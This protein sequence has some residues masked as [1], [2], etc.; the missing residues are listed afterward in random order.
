MVITIV[1][2]ACAVINIFQDY[3]N[4]Y[5]H[6]M[7]VSLH[8]FVVILL[9]FGLLT[10]N[11]EASTQDA[12]SRFSFAIS[13]GASKGAYES[14]LNWSVIKIGRE[15]P[16]LKDIT[17]GQA[18]QLEAGSITGAS[19]GGINTLLSGLTWC[20]RSE[21]EGGLS[22]RIDNNV[23]RDIWLRIDINTLLPR[24]ADSPSYLPDDAVLSRKDFLDAAAELRDKWNKPM[25]RK[26]CRIPLGVT[27]TRIEPDKLSVGNVEV[28]NQRFY[29]PFELRVTTDNSIDFFFDP[30]DYPKVADPAMI[31]MP[32]PRNAP[33]FS[34]DDQRVEDAAF[35]TSAFPMAFGR[36]RLQ[37]CRLIVQEISDENNQQNQETVKTNTDLVC[38][39]GYELA[40]AEFAD[41]GLFDNLPIGVA[42]ILA[43]R[44]ARA[45]EDPYPVTY[46]YLDPNRVRYKIP[47]AKKD[48]AC[49][50]PNPPIA[51][52]IM[53]FSFASESQ[54][55]LSFLGTA[56]RYEL[57]R[58]LT[59]EDWQLNM[60]E[61][62]YKL[63]DILREREIILDCQKEI[64]F[65]DRRLD[66]TESLERAGHL[67]EIAY[68]RKTPI[69]EAPYS[70][71]RL[72][73]AGIIKQC[74]QVTSNTGSQ[75]Q[76][77]CAFDI[78]RY[79]KVLADG[80]TSIAEQTKLTR[81]KIYSD[82]SKSRLSM[83]NDRSLR[84]SS[85]SAPITG[86]L[87][88]S[89]GSFL[90]Y[91]FREYDYYVGVYDGLIMVA[92]TSCGLQYS[93]V[94]Q[95]ED[96]RQCFDSVSKQLYTILG[97]KNDP[98]GRYVFAGLAQR[99]YG[100]DK[101]LRFAYEPMPTADRDMQIIHDGLFKALAAG[102][103]EEVFFKYLKA[104]DFTPTP[105]KDGKQPLLA[106]I[107]DDS[108]K[109][110]SEL[111]RRLTTRL[112]YLDAQAD[113]VYAAREPDK[114]KRDSAYTELMGVAAFGLQSYT[115]RY[116]EFSFAPST[117]PDTWFWRN[118]I[119]FEFGFDI[120]EGD[121]LLT[122]QPT[123]ALSKKDLL[124]V[125]ASVG[126][127]GGLIASSADETRENYLAVGID[128][129]RQTTFPVISS[130][131]LTP[132]WYHSFTKP[133]VGDQ[134]TLGGDV[135]VSFLNNR[136]RVGV[137]TR[138]FD[139]VSDSWFLTL[140]IADLPGMIYW[141]TR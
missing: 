20:S 54:L 94:S 107:I 56:R 46:I 7:K 121:L 75:F 140:G 17:G 91:K 135:H 15:I 6:H 69:I 87:L 114:S 79:R 72:K 16:G 126:F 90:E 96:Y 120:V 134:D 86:T 23:F 136:L 11:I 34:I 45:E 5:C 55:I 18:L 131:G 113:K 108:D 80:L 35:T 24:R 125:R 12:H 48:L 85:R 83:Q 36:K 67:L 104:E 128:Y 100:K 92:D 2:R 50:S 52:R 57:Y 97:I 118:I 39:A 84:V 58:E 106:D 70:V 129:S 81:N 95:S 137:G 37:Y 13:G 102:E 61:I 76:S 26:G 112:V 141:L 60:S 74:K 101:L 47:E 73:K 53:E 22:N 51:C 38:P 41:G 10:G 71:D 65:F 4:L 42:R 133:Q 32:R 110:A 82:I 115:Y 93:T 78:R 27:V 139:N 44:N 8:S 123:L 40:E 49:N 124:G 130:F 89:F 31:L 109:W 28:Q 43:E 99:E 1:K 103:S 105:S 117:A 138:D 63:A 29:I 77:A 68:D 132:T 25:F 98:R 64:P 62:S 111:T 116:P 66:C 14:G 21:E 59:S 19:A 88:E 119:P 9:G 122:W 33:P 127:A 3:S 30:A